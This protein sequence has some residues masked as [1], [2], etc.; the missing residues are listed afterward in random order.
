M[1]RTTCL[2]IKHSGIVK[3]GQIYREN[4]SSYIETSGAQ[5]LSLASRLLPKFLH[6]TPKFKIHQGRACGKSSKEEIQNLPLRLTTNNIY[7]L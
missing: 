3:V 1:Q 2:R 7:H 5:V 6:L 4:T